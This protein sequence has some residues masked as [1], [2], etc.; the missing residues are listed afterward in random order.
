[1]GSEGLRTQ[2]E[3]KLEKRIQEHV[4]KHFNYIA[5]RAQDFISDRKIAGVILGG[6]KTEIGLF[7][8]HLPKQLREKVM[9]DFVSEFHTNFDDILQRSKKVIET[10]A[11]QNHRTAFV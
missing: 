5:H 6:H 10:V 1:M 4:H 3:N 2:K 7:R 11:L 8:E 9:G